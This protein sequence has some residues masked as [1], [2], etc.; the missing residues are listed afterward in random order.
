MAEH[1]DR[2]TV[3]VRNGEDWHV[4]YSVDSDAA[5]TLMGEVRSSEDRPDVSPQ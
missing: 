3:V 4:G 5:L 1:N 2:V